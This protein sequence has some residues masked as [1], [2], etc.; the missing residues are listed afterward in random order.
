MEKMEKQE[1]ELLK[2]KIRMHRFNIITNIILIVIIL[3]IS[4]YVIK[5]IELFKQLNQDICKLCMQKTG[6]ICFQPIN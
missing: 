2:K 5:E 1:E 6:A 4:I 3:G